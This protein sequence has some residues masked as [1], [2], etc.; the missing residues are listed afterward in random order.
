MAFEP[1]DNSGSIFVNDKGDNP[2]RPD[3]KGQAM[4]GGVEYWVKGWLKKTKDGD[5]FLSLSFEP[6]GEKQPTTS[7][8]Q[9]RGGGG[10]MDDNIPFAPEWR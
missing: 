1:K 5:P 2:K 8:M 3:R 10:D 7:K 6:K 9:P 4:I